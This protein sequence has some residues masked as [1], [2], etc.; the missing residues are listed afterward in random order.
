[1]PTLVKLKTEAARSFLRDV[2]NE[3]DIFHIFFGKTTPWDNDSAPPAVTDTRKTDAEAHSDLLA[4]KR[5]G[6][7]DV[8]FLIPNVTWDNDG[9]LNYGSSQG[10][11]Y[12]RYVD[13]ADLSTLNFY[14]YNNIN[15]CIYKCLNRQDY[16]DAKDGVVFPPAAVNGDYYTSEP[17]KWKLVDG[18]WLLVSRV[19]PSDVTG[20]EKFQTSDGYWWKMVYKIPDV[21]REKFASPE[22]LPVRFIP[23]PSQLDTM[24]HIPF[25]NGII[26][27][28]AGSGYA[29]PPAVVITGDGTGAH[30]VASIN[31]YGEVVGI[32]VVSGG[33][34]YT[35]AFATF[36]S[37]SGTGCR[38]TVNLVA[39]G[40]IP[41]DLNVMISATAQ[42]TAGAIEFIDII[43]AGENYSANSQ[44]YVEGDGEGATL[45]VIINDA[46][47]IESIQTENMGSG[48]T[49]ANIVATGTGEG[50]VFKPI[51]SPVWGHGGNVPTELLA[52]MVGIVVDVDAPFIPPTA[53]GDFFE[54]NDFRQV[55]VIKN[56]R[57]YGIYRNVFAPLNGTQYYTATVS[58]ISAYSLHDTITTSIGGVFRVEGF[59]G[60]G[61]VKLLPLIDN[62]T[63]LSALYNVTSASALDALVSLVEPER[64]S[65]LFTSNTGDSCYKIEVPAPDFANYNLDDIIVSNEGGKFVVVEKNPY[66]LTNTVKLLPIADFIDVNSVLTN[67]TTSAPLAAI[68]SLIPPE[69]NKKTGDIIY[70]KN[71]VPYT[72]QRYQT[73]TVK[74]YLQF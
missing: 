49:Y 73:E 22:Y 60:T 63:L 12:D 50:A 61:E 41:E 46:G 30:A 19:A 67:Q 25:V 53:Q 34:G 9:G 68:V 13:D 24:G 47:G 17:Y 64:T 6:P 21:D 10:T 15:Y 52:T 27:D 42:A 33:H 44:F 36:L 2:V 26:I 1:M 51:I 69:V 4:V 43:S 74:L 54:G 70:L 7:T 16:V 11:V 28:E 37:N 20:T 57:E 55:G 3:K 39:D 66:P 31:I 14:V 58:D 29:T 32:E 65:D 71:T 40:P 23:S 8:T 56:I 59:G 62:I 48:Y 72:R 45:S 5:I 35:F 38:A 18:E